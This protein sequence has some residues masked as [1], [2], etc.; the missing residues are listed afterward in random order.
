[1]K[2]MFIII[3]ILWCN[4]IKANGQ[5]I[6]KFYFNDKKE[7]IIQGI[8]YNQIKVEI[9]S[10][11][12]PKNFFF[13]KQ[14]EKN[15]QKTYILKPVQ[16]KR[17][18][19]IRLISFF[20]F[21]WF[22]KKHYDYQIKFNDLK[23]GLYLF[24]IKEETFEKNYYVLISDY[25]LVTKLLY[26]KCNNF[27]INTFNG[28]PEKKFELFLINENESK[29]LTSNDDYFYDII[30][31]KNDYNLVA[32]YSNQCDINIITKD[33]IKFNNP[34]DFIEIVLFKKF[35]IIGENLIFN[36]LLKEKENF[37]YK[38]ISIS[39]VEISI[40]DN[41]NRLIKLKNSNNIETGFLTDSF[42]LDDLFKEGIY[43]IRVK[44]KDQ[45]Q[46]KYIYILEKY[47]PQLYFKIITDKNIY[48]YK[49]KIKGEI[50]VYNKYGNYLKEGKLNIDILVKN[51]NSSEDY[52]YLTS[53]NKKLKKGKN[54]FNL[55][56]YELLKEND[57]LIKIIIKVRSNNGFQEADYRIIKII[58]SGYDIQINNEYEIFEIGNPIELKYDLI[59]LEEKA[60]IKDVRISIYKIDNFDKKTKSFIKS[61]KMKKDEKN[62]IFQID[63]N[64]LYEAQ[65]SIQDNMNYI[66]KK[67]INFW[68]LSYT[69]GIDIKEKLNDIIIIENKK[70][71]NYS[72]I[73]KV[74]IIF[75]NKNIWYNIYIEGN[76]TYYNKIEFSEKNYI[77]FDFPL[78]EKYSP[79]VLLKVIVYNTNKLY[80]KQVS[81]KI[82]YIN[83]SLKIN[84]E[85]SNK[86][87]NY[88]SNKIKIESLNYWG[89]G[90]SSY[91]LFYTLNKNYFELYNEKDYDLY[92]KLY[93]QLLSDSIVINNTD[94]IKKNIY[95]TKKSDYFPG[96]IYS[97]YLESSLNNCD[98]LFFNKNQIYEKIIKYSKYGFWTSYLFGFTDDTKIGASQL[99]HF[100]I[101]DYYINYYI[102]NYLSIK[103]LIYFTIVIK[104]N[105][106]FNYKFKFNFNILNG[107]YKA[108]MNKYLSVD[109]D[110]Y[111]KLLLTFKPKFNSGTKIIINNIL[112]TE[113]NSK[114]FFIKAVK[115]P[116]I[117]KM[118]NALL[119][120]DKNYYKLKFYSNRNN[121]YSKLM[122]PGWFNFKYDCGDDVIIRYK[123]KVKQEIRNIKIIDYVPAGLEYIKENFKYQLYNIIPFINY[124]IENNDEKMI[125][126]IPKLEKGEYYIYYILKAKFMGKYFLPGY[127]VLKDNK[128][129]LS[130]P[131]NDYVTIY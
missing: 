115:L 18:I 80:Y 112:P 31:E 77:L 124:S 7:I 19:F 36:I 91:L 16:I 39:S 5:E 59:Q 45:I 43:K 55:K 126:H 82:P 30:L 70:E 11:I 92:S 28:Q 41:Q 34:E 72:D 47:K 13:F 10:I 86:Y 42:L 8:T 103:D 3:I 68:V 100:Y 111:Q 12:T 129:I 76:E 78:Y 108:E 110:Q 83:K 23:P 90:I 2:K 118:K 58:K 29:I 33:Q 21:Y 57:Y 17:N 87:Y 63:N 102:P 120:I 69:Y 122:S 26:N 123:I 51:L 93:S 127:T 22:Q 71:Y 97:D 109:K 96:Y 130:V 116:A 119:K 50:E 15:L 52:K 113:I 46:T 56:V 89:H 27:L 1:M 65:F 54:K 24:Q 37:N 125:L 9:Y 32:F 114:E 35:Y 94:I 85:L 128:L 81:I 61:K 62:F 38:N 14:I 67:S 44:W 73:G 6:K 25:K 20:K 121:Y 99:Q 60:K 95:K 40:W 49:E 48:F 53:L 117:E 79:E 66:V 106:N 75:P 64:G 105:I 4:I 88:E 84:S 101:N 104:N 131:E 98:L 107:K 74:L